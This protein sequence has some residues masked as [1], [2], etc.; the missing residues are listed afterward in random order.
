MDVSLEE[1]TRYGEREPLDLARKEAVEQ[2][3][4]LHFPEALRPESDVATE[5]DPGLGDTS[6][7]LG[8]PD[9]DA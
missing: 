2:F 1:L 9:G 3:L 4:R 7:E 8:P 5:F 6:V